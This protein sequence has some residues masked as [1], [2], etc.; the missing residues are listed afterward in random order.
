MLQAMYSRL[1][2]RQ[3]SNRSFCEQLTPSKCVLSELNIET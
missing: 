1:N 3:L 2:V